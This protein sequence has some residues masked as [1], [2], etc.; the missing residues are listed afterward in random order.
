MA[1]IKVDKPKTEIAKRRPA[2]KNKGS[3]KPATVLKVQEAAKMLSKG[4]SRATIIQHFMDTYG[5]SVKTAADYYE[6]GTRFLMPDNESEFKQN[7]IKANATR[8]ETIYER[9]MEAGDF[10]N[11]KEAIAELNKMIGVGKEGITVGINTDKENDTQQ[12]LI[13]FDK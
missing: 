10:K 4:K 9:A 6:A 13:R 2:S 3:S 5:L 12:V 7:L 8:L 11:A 1:T